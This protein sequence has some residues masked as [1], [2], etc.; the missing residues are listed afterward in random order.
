MVD[1]GQTYSRLPS[2]CRINFSVCLSV[3]PNVRPSGIWKSKILNVGIKIR[4]HTWSFLS[5]VHP[6]YDSE[7][8]ATRAR[9]KTI[10][11]NATL[12]L[13][14]Y[15]LG[16]F[17]GIVKKN[18]PGKLFFYHQPVP[19]CCTYVL[20]TR[21]RCNILLIEDL[22]RLRAQNTNQPWR[23]LLHL[24]PPTPRWWNHQLVWHMHCPPV[25]AHRMGT[26]NVP[27]R[28]VLMEIFGWTVVG[29]LLVLE[30]VDVWHEI[31]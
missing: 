15:C 21:G 28:Q 2:P 14:P 29:F 13:S 23:L 5:A 16:T 30:L 26:S 6:H 24:E 8:L 11:C 17:D 7:M 18:M 12:L 9:C 1:W 25:H 20:C 3:R 10:V 31:S 4:V 19:L 22:V 27:I